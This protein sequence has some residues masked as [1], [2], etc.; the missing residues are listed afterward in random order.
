MGILKREFIVE[1][2]ISFLL[3]NALTMHKDYDMFDILDALRSS[4][5]VDI[6]SIFEIK[7]NSKVRPSMVS[8]RIGLT[9]TIELGIEKIDLGFY[10]LI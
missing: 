2:R 9:V 8:K 6:L 1:I 3:I 5:S 4:K 10:S 7:L